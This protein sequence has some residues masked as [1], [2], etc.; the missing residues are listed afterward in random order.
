MR[1][2]KY[3]FPSTRENWKKKH[4]NECEQ[5]IVCIFTVKKHPNKWRYSHSKIRYYKYWR[6]H[7]ICFF[8]FCCLSQVYCKLY[9]GNFRS[10]T[11]I[12]AIGEQQKPIKQNNWKRK[13]DWLICW[14]WCDYCRRVYLLF[15][16]VYRKIVVGGSVFIIFINIVVAVL[17]RRIILLFRFEIACAIHTWTGNLS[18]EQ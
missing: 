16:C 2:K 4:E 8:S 14:T 5:C 7:S 10:K 12:S 1:H 6:V 15:K 11:F 18:I 3:N 13:T 17:V 9:L